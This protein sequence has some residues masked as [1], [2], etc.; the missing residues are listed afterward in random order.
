VVVLLVVG[1]MVAGAPM[2]HWV[3]TAT[4]KRW[5]TLGS[6]PLM[7]GFAGLALGSVSGSLPWRWW[8]PA[9]YAILASGWLTMAGRRDR[10][11]HANLDG[12]GDTGSSHDGEL[13]LPLY[14]PLAAALSGLLLLLQMA[15]ISLDPTPEFVLPLPKELHLAHTDDLGCGSQVCSRRLV[16][17][18]EPGQSPQE[19]MAEVRTFLINRRGWEL[20]EAG[21]GCRD[22]G[23]LNSGSTCFELAIIDNK[24]TILVSDTSLWP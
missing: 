10:Q 5:R 16:V 11:L 14:A 8:L 21:T 3:L 2:I 6:L 22:S 17:V 1:A 19:I 20:D 24:T 15:N 23:I 9:V 18:G 7:A 12:R 13:F 4:T